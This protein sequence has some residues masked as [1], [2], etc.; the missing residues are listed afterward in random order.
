MGS[1]VQTSHTTDTDKED[2]TS[3]YSPGRE[4]QRFSSAIKEQ[5]YQ[6]QRGTLHSCC[7]KWSHRNVLIVLWLRNK[8]GASR[9]VCVPDH[10][11]F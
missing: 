4:L 11:E 9:G 3:R 6:D 10:T 2:A 7:Y 8:H 5:R 1:I